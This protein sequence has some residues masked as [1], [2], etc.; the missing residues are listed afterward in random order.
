M[1]RDLSKV[2]TEID[3]LKVGGPAEDVA[4]RKRSVWQSFRHWVAGVDSEQ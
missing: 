2:K 3:R 4:S 1:R